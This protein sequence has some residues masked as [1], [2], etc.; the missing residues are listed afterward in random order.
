MAEVPARPRGLAALSTAETR[1]KSRPLWTQTPA[2][3]APRAAR[4]A[5]P[6]K[7]EL[8]LPPIPRCRGGGLTRSASWDRG[9]PKK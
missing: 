5:C 1:Q 2:P 6:W 8:R 3:G 7:E 4:C 9:I